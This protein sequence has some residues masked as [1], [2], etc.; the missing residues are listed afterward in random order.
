MLDF[1]YT[2]DICC[3]FG[4]LGGCVGPGVYFV[5]TGQ[6]KGAFLYLHQST[7]ASGY[8]RYKCFITMQ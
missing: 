3:K 6:G 8:K 7:Y 2:I 1:I 4:I 5:P